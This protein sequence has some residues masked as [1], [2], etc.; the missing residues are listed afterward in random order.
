VMPPSAA[1]PAGDPL[2]PPRRQPIVFDNCVDDAGHRDGLFRR[3]PDVVAIEM[4]ERGKRHD[5]RS[6]SRSTSPDRWSCASRRHA[7][8]GV[9]RASQML[10]SPG[11]STQT[12]IA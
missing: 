11:A 12:F 7:A 2:E 6:S 3:L 10:V 4:C 8:G 9:I 5:T 1:K